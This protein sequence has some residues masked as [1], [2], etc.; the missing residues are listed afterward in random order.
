MR[1]VIADQPGGPEALRLVDLPDPEPGP[2][3]VLLRI[4]ASALNRADVLQRMGLYP[5]PPGASEVLGMECSGVVERVGEGVDGWRPGDRAAGLLSAGGYAELCAVPEGQLL[6]V[7]DGMSMIEA[8][9][10]PE[11]FLT[12]FDNMITRGGLRPGD[13]VL[14]HGGAGGIGTAAIQLARRLGAVV[15]VTAGSDERLHASRELGATHAINHRTEDFVERVAELTDGRG[16]DV[17]LDVMG[18]S[19]LERNLAA[20][21]TEGRLVIIGLQGGVRAE[22]DLNLVMRRRLRVMGST[23]RARSVAEKSAV[24]AA[25]QREVMP[26]FEDGTLRPVVGRVVDLADVADAHRAMEAGEVIGKIVLRVTPD[27]GDAAR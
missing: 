14:V 17:V 4:H 15:I 23:L 22:I 26:G 6:R 21:A 10:V 27:A 12:A 9:A 19:Y 11:V 20:L 2:G 18:A 13:W 3:E 24:V 5:P 16:V 1:A 25:A 8:A 7:P